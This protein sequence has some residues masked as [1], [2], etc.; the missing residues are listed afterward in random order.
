MWLHQYSPAVNAYRGVAESGV[1]SATWFTGD[2]EVVTWSL[3]T[4][5]GTASRWTL[6]GS[7][8]DGFRTAINASS[9]FTLAVASA[10]GF[11][12]VD[13]IPRWARFQRTPSAS[14]STVMLGFRVGG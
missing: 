4:S 6:S 10:Q 8:D 3:M 12:S 13:T 11:Y 2:A 1:T 9:W 14:S 5:S 7:M